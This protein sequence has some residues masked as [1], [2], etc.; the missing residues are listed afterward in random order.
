MKPTILLALGGL[1]SIVAGYR[2]LVNGFPLLRQLASIL[3]RSW[4]IERLIYRHHRLVGGAIFSGALTF[5][6]LLG[7]LHNRVLSNEFSGP[8]G[9]ALLVQLVVAAAWGFAVLALL[10]GLFVIIRPS[11]L[12]GLESL[13]N[14]HIELTPSLL[15]RPPVP[16]PTK[17]RRKGIAFLLVGAACLCGYFIPCLSC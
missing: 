11:V 13:A 6:T 5:L 14:R 3:D 12:K 4:R 7:L 8:P 2:I 15:S 10:I 9:H 1:L 17:T 16:D